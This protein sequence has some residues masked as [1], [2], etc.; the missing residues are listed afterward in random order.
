MVNELISLLEDAIK[1]YNE[2]I[3]DIN[4]NLR[5]LEPAYKQLVTK[6]RKKGVIKVDAMDEDGLE[7]FLEVL[8]Y[9]NRVLYNKIMRLNEEGYKLDKMLEDS[10]V[11]WKDNMT[12]VSKIQSSV[13]YAN[14]EDELYIRAREIFTHACTYYV[15]LYESIEQEKEEIKDINKNYEYALKNIKS[16]KTLTTRDIS[17]IT[18]LINELMLMEQDK[19]ELFDELNN[20]IKNTKKEKIINVPEK[21]EVIKKEVKYIDDANEIDLTYEDEEEEKY[22]YNYLFTLKSFDSFNDVN[23]FLNSI[24]YTCDINTVIENVI[25]LLED[26]KEDNLLKLYLEKYMFLI[27]ESEEKE[28]IEEHQEDIN[29][30]ILYYGFHDCKNNILNDIE[31]SDIPSEYFVDIKEIINM[32]KTGTDK[33][34]FKRISSIRKVLKLRYKDIR[35]TYKKLS[36][37]IIIILGVFCKKDGKGYD[38]INITNKRNK[39]LMK[40]EKNIIESVDIPELWNEYLKENNNIEEEIISTLTSYIK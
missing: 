23:S 6:K 38:I 22:A 32:I 9:N 12:I 1:F 35:I 34:K 11:S 10:S 27:N 29:N 19:K 28:A 7:L 18:N 40:Y 20:Y 17:S 30:T 31:K 5:Y 21:E 15:N 4:K 13:E 3:K 33:G 37:D 26:T 25:S 24:K 2:E 14:K 8:L 36:N 16:R 39:E